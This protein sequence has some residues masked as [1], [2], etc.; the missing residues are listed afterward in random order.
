MHGKFRCPIYNTSCSQRVKNLFLFR[1]IIIFIFIIIIN[2]RDFSSLNWPKIKYLRNKSKKPRHIF[3]EMDTFNFIL[4]AKYRKQ[5]F[6]MNDTRTHDRRSSR[7]K[8][9]QLCPEMS[10]K[11]KTYKHFIGAGHY[12]DQEYDIYL[13]Y[14]IIL[15]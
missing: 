3:D 12:A 1:N 13:R 5:G 4:E 9:C 2:N 6:G 7:S 14:D 8:H 11:I 10:K 15:Y